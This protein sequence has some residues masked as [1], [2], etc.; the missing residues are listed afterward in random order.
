VASTDTDQSVGI[1]ETR[2]VSPVF[3]YRCGVLGKGRVF[4]IVTLLLKLSLIQ[5]SV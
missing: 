1:M 3:A 4:S 5:S 2:Y